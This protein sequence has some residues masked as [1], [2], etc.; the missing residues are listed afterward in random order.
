MDKRKEILVKELGKYRVWFTYILEETYD[1]DWK[2]NIITESEYS[3][4]LQPDMQI[5]VVEQLSDNSSLLA[6]S[7]DF[8]ADSDQ[9]AV[10]K[11]KEV[12]ETYGFGWVGEY[13]ITKV[14]IEPLVKRVGF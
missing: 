8:S 12:L 11:T 3:L 5:D 6:V 7:I 13:Y 9:D 14:V 1:E 10:L 2:E 4:I